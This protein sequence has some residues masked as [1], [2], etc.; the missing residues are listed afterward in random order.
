MTARA[1][2]SSHTHI[3][4]YILEY[5]KLLCCI[6][7]YKV[8]GSAFLSLNKS[9]RVFNSFYIKHPLKAPYSHI[10]PGSPLSW[11]RL[12]CY[13][14]ELRCSLQRDPSF[15]II[16]FFSACCPAVINYSVSDTVL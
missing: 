15:E 9:A 3:Y 2:W 6:A 5:K 13:R 7:Y 1:K 8:S 12:F 11:L 14:D 4:T 16:E 10:K